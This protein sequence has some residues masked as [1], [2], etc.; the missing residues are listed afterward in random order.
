DGL[1][2]NQRNGRVF[3]C[4]GS[5]TATSLGRSTSG[6]F[7][8]SKLAY[9]GINLQNVPGKYDNSDE[10]KENQIKKCFPVSVVADLSAAHSKIA[11]EVAKDT[12]SIEVELADGD[13]HLFTA[14]TLE[15]ML[16]GSL[17]FDDM[18]LIKRDKKHPKYDYVNGLR[19]LSKSTR[20]SSFNLG[21]SARLQQTLQKA[22]LSFTLE[23]CKEAIKA[24]R[25]NHKP[26]YDYQMRVIK[27]ANKH[28]ITF[29]DSPFTY[30]R[31]VNHI[32]SVLFMPK[33]VSQFSKDGKPEV[34][35]ADCCSHKWMAVESHIMKSAM[36]RIQKTF[37]KNPQW[38]AKLVE[39]THDE[40]GA[41]CRP[42]YKLEVA[43]VVFHGMDDEMKRIVKSIPTTQDTA[44]KCIVT[45]WADK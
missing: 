36:I 35:A 44:E 16:G 11:V 15:K 43:K 21:G 26:I 34:K 38:G 30:G 23:E 22:G 8:K 17:T 7:T 2:D 29:S 42:D 4:Y 13:I 28:N 40:I 39:M 19:N 18:M 32:G 10:A 37:D 5:L 25:I 24:W 1:L 27:E 20:Y 9:D 14:A 31:T 41:E 12:L 3:T 33:Q 45:S 6:K